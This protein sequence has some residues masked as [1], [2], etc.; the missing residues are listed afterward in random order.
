MDTLVF[1]LLT[2]IRATRTCLSIQISSLWKARRVLEIDIA[3]I[4]SA[5][6]R[7][8]EDTVMIRELSRSASTFD[9]QMGTGQQV[10]VQSTIKFAF[11]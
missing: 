4:I 11:L 2:E 6:R 3:D 8:L 9:T 10:F 5:S 1:C 7:K